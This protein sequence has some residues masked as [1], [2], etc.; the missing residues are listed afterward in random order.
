MDQ[1]LDILGQVEQIDFLD[2]GLEGV[3]ARIDTG[4]RTSTL[5]ASNIAE[6]DGKLSF[7]LFDEGYP[8]H[9]GSVIT[10]ETF[11]TREVTSS[12][13]ATEER[14]MIWL[15]VRVAGR[16]IRARFTLANR[17][18]QR[19]PVLIGRN[20]LRGKFIVNIKHQTKSN[21]VN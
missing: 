18:T 21:N 13:G 11:E 17:S 4:A 2:F 14:Y 6:Q 1:K 19:Y 8:K 7:K 9:D 5:W 15:R 20:L 16:T 3:P 12:N 10:M